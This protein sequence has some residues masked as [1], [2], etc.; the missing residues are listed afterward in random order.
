VTRNLEVRAAYLFHRNQI[1]KN[2]LQVRAGNRT[3]RAFLND[4]ELT[5]QRRNNSFVELSVS[6]TRY[7]GAAQLDLIGSL[8]QGVPWFGAQADLAGGPPDGPTF[9]YRLQTVDASLTAPFNLGGRRMQYTTTVHGQHTSHTLY[10][11]EQF[12][13]GNRWTVRGFDG[14]NTLS[15]DSGVFLR[16]DLETAVGQ[17]ASLY[18]GLDAGRVRGGNAQPLPGRTLAGIVLGLKG[19]LK[20]CVNFNAFLGGPLHQPACFAKP[21]LTAG[22]SASFHF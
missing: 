20:K 8:R 19:V 22:I 6:H 2:T 18:V 16:N 11:T 14:G 21:W 5:V 7:L 1:S 4:T 9:Y 12:T 13:I 3:S 15:S 10:A 17:V